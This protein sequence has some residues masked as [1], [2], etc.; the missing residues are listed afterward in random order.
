V[1]VSV[2]VASP[3]S[4]ISKLKLLKIYLRSKMLQERLNT[5]ASLYIE[6][7]L[8]DKI[9]TDVIINDFASRNVRKF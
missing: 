7:I 2:T 3:K 6:K 8:V 5:L 1:I 4:N 9:D